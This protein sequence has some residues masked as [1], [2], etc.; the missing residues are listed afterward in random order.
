[1]ERLDESIHKR[2]NFVELLIK[3]ISNTA[4]C[5]AYEFSN[6]FSPFYFPIFVNE[7]IVSCDKLTFAKALQAEGI[8]LGEHY[9]CI[10]SD[11]GWAKEYMYDDFVATNASSTRDRSFNLHLNE[12]YGEQEVDDIV[13]SIIKV[14]NYFMSNISS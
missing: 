2:I 6:D 4:S 3:K 8:T 1:M 5:T 13:S 10:V 11:W 9:G 7:D 14:E 12:N